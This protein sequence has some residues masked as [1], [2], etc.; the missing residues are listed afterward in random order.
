MTRRDAIALIPPLFAPAAA[1]AKAGAILEDFSHG[2]ENWWVEGGERVWVEGGRLHMRAD[3]PKIPGGG[4]AT[5]WCK[6]EHPADFSLSL[7][8]NVISSAPDVNNINLFFC[9]TDPSGVALYQTR[10]ARK[11][12]EYEAYHT[13]R[14]YIVTFLNGGEEG[15]LNADGSYKARIRIRRNPGFV[16]LAETFKKQC[17]QGVTYRVGI[18]KQ[19]GAIAFSV[20]GETLLEATDPQ[21]L[22]AGLLGLRTYRTYLWWDNIRLTPV[23]G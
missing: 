19:G 17:R 1:R 9:Y 16:I 14:G 10:D 18:R 20:D 8:A 11:F 13:L 22:G 23:S 15:G 12:A 5:A 7:D 2:L 6:K 4:V 3:N 21:P